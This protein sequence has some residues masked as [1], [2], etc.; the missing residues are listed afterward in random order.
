MAQPGLPPLQFVTFEKLPS[1]VKLTRAALAGECRKPA[2]KPA[3]RIL[4]SLPITRPF[5][6][7][8]YLMELILT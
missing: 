4:N 6:Q 5:I 3:V 2:S 7:R 1:P 8:S